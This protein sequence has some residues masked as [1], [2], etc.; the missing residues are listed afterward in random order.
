MR[1]LGFRATD[2]ACAE[3]AF[4]DYYE[5]KKEKSASK[6]GEEGLEISKLGISQDIVSQLAK[7]G[8]TALFPIQ[9]SGFPVLTVICF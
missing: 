2:V 8:I 5:E 6:S 1:S 7:K 9:V 3:Y 4:D